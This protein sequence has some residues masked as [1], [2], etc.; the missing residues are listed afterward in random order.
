MLELVR[1]HHDVLLE[2]LRGQPAEELAEVAT[3]ASEFLLE[4]LATYDMAQ[5][6]FL[7]GTVG[8]RTR[9]GP[10]AGRGVT[11][12]RPRAPAMRPFRPCTDEDPL[13]V[14]P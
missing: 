12:S 13:A 8:A 1:V 3:A 5:R 2:V 7:D 9:P 6:G 11:S 14:A 10:L 4:V